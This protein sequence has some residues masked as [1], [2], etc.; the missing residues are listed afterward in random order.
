MLDRAM[1]LAIPSLLLVSL[2]WPT[3]TN[4]VG[5]SCAASRVAIGL[6]AWCL[7]P[8][9]GI[10]RIVRSCTADPMAPAITPIGIA[11]WFIVASPSSI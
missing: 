3:Y 8:A 10:E 2:R 4:R 7:I 5:G 6:M 11:S 9:G 1:L